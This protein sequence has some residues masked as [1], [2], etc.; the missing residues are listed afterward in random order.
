MDDLLPEL[1]D[2]YAEQLQIAIPVLRNL[3]GRER[4]NGEIVTIKAFEDNSLVRDKTAENGVGKVLV[5]DSGGS[6]R[7]AM[8]GDML[9]ARALENG[10]EGI[11]IN[12]CIRDINAIARLNIGVQALGVHPLKTEKLGAGQAGI[13]LQFAGIHFIPG[14]HLYADN[15]GLAV[16][17]NPLQIP[18]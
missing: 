15:N 14:H 12:G 16:S 10:W 5:I 4:F 18:E 9:A 3:G 8:L 6:L 7:C 17:V 11:V 13:P 2:R 1:C